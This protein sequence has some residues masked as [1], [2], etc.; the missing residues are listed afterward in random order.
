VFDAIV[1]AG[2]SARR[3]DGAD[4]PALMIGGRTLLDRVIDA[5]HGAERIVVVGPERETRTHVLQVRE[6]PPGAG[7]VAAV[8]AG[9]GLVQ[10]AWCLVLAADLPWIAPAVPLLLTAARGADAAVLVT[11]GQRNHLAAVWRTDALRAAVRRLGQL[12][13][14]P[15]RAL[16]TGVAVTEVHD[17]RDWGQD[18]DTWDDVAHA[19]AKESK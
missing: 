11:A 3:L 15:A 4:K 10:Q 9:L 14:A 16:Y 13:D 5:A 8:A 18:C 1:L 7:P 6:D 2:G 12:A 19:R 17:D